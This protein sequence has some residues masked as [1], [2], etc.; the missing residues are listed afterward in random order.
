MVLVMVLLQK[1]FLF[2][3]VGCVFLS[4]SIFLSHNKVHIARFTLNFPAHILSVKSQIRGQI[5]K[6]HVLQTAGQAA[7]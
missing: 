4:I 3:Y 6:H 5:E 2:S 1:E 7:N